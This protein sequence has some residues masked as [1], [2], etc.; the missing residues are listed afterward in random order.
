MP[1]SIPLTKRL[2]SPCWLRR[3]VRQTGQVSQTLARARSRLV[4][5]ALLMS[6][7]CL[8]AEIISITG[9]IFPFFAASVNPSGI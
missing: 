5:S 9:A 3:A 6:V 8:L 4:I 1:T 7:P 2:A